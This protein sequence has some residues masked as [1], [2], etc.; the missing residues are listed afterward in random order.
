MPNDRLLDRIRALAPRR[1][2][3][4]GESVVNVSGAGTDELLVHVTAETSIDVVQS[5][6]VQLEERSSAAQTIGITREHRRDDA[7]G[8]ALLSRVYNF[9]LAA[10]ETRQVAGGRLG[11]PRGALLRPS[12]Y[13]TLSSS[14]GGAYGVDL[15]LVVARYRVGQNAIE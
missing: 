8:E 12:T 3:Y 15:Q 13:I 11:Y 5:L 6:T 7:A 1:F 9:D 14:A 4:R 2:L 10:D